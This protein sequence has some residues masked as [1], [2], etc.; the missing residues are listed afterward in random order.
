MAEKQGA[1][2][3]RS[4]DPRA[5][6]VSSAKGRSVAEERVARRKAEQE[7][8]PRYI[9]NKVANNSSAIHSRALRHEILTEVAVAQVLAGHVQD[10]LKTGERP[11][12]KRHVSLLSKVAETQVKH[13]DVDGAEE[14]LTDAL[15]IIGG[16]RGK[17]WDWDISD[18]RA[19]VPALEKLRRTPRLIENLRR[20]FDRLR[21]SYPAPELQSSF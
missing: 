9:L 12:A 7:R 18:L 6:G 13:G 8:D 19:I 2:G 16:K 11:G 21:K 3:N 15:T 17:A 1:R 5:V 4:P 10:A 14:T 20:L